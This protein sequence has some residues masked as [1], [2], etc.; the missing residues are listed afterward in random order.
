MTISWIWHSSWKNKKKQLEYKIL[1]SYGKPF[2]KQKHS[3][4]KQAQI[5]KNLF[6]KFRSLLKMNL[7]N[8]SASIVIPSY[9]NKAGLE[10]VLNAMLQLNFA[11]EY[12]I[13][14]IDDGSID[15]TKEM[16][17]KKF[18][19]EKKIKLVFLTR[20]QVVCKARNAGIT[21]AQFSIVIN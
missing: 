1:I 21:K 3:S 18:G 2:R 19:T 11:G 6:K 15:G 4:P 13:I 20:N 16:L 7:Q 9:N 8:N 5:S 12:E 14:I 17:E 10:K